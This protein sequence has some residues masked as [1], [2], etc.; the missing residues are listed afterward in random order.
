MRISR[1][2]IPTPKYYVFYNGDD[3]DAGSVDLR[4]S[5]AYKGEGDLEV[6]AHVL[7]INYDKEKG[8][9]GKCKPLQDYA[10]IVDLV[11]KYCKEGL[12]KEAAARRAVE[13]GI[14]EGIL[15]DILRKEKNRASK[16]V[17]SKV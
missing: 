1:I 16:K 14:E 8:L 17:S 11:R 10:K 12:P 9:L 5:D 13:D 2:H 3:L 7:N 15:S 4:L 6:I